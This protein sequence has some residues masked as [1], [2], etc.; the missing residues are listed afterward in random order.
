MKRQLNRKKS[1]QLNEA[2]LISSWDIAIK[3]N[4]DIKMIDKTFK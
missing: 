2:G 1:L 3:K 4:H